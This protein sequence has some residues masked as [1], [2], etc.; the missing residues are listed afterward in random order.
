MTVLVATTDHGLVYGDPASLRAMHIPGGITSPLPDVNASPSSEEGQIISVMGQ[1][2]IQHGT[3]STEKCN[4]KK[5]KKILEEKGFEP[6]TFGKSFFGL[7]GGRRPRPPHPAAA[8]AAA[9]HRSNC[10][11][12]DH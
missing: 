8:A 5:G 3:P 7:I 1:L 10:Q 6:S 4:K 2:I 12:L 9:E 11:R